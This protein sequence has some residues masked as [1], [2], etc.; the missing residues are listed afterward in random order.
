MVSPVAA[1]RT[2]S[3]AAAGSRAGGR[4]VGRRAQMTTL[5]RARTTQPQIFTVP[6]RGG[7]RLNRFG[8]AIQI[9]KGPMMA[10]DS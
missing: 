5:P 10:T 2:R 6:T 9:Q 8:E 7:Q 1:H 3:G 4:R